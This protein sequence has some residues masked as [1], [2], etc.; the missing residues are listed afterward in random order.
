MSA[1]NANQSANNKML[2][3]L[4][5]NVYTVPDGEQLIGADG[6]LNPRPH[7]GAN[8]HIMEQTTTCNLITG[9]IWLTR[10]HYVKNTM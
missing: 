5:Y 9:A 8:I 1:T 3:E 2:S 4:G 7:W 6:K 10:T